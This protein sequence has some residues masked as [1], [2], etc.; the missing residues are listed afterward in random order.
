LK[1]LVLKA[2]SS[3]YCSLPGVVVGGADV[4]SVVEALEAVSCREKLQLVHTELQ[5]KETAV[6]GVGI[7]AD[8]SE[9]VD[10]VAVD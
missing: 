8:S 5:T 2:K 10:L 7:V 9:L 6:G 1:R 4:W 3:V